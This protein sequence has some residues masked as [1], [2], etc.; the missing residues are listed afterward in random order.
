MTNEERLDF[1]TGDPWEEPI[2]KCDRLLQKVIPGYKIT[3]IKNKFNELRYYISYPEG[4]TFH[5]D[6]GQIA[7]AIISQAE[8]EVFRIQGYHITITDPKNEE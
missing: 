7:W 8:M 5:S 2:R 3:D 4:I 1:W 6:E